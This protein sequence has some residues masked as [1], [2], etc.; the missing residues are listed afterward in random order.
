[1]LWID[2][3]G[4]SATAS[5]AMAAAL[6]A[7]AARNPLVAVMGSVAGSG[8]YY[9]ATPAARIFAQPSTLTGSIGV[10][11]GKLAVGGL[12][13]RLLLNLETVT[14]RE[15][16]SMFGPARAFRGEDEVRLRE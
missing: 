11:S 8:G 15:H 3:G 4:G 16:A 12:L 9:V 7:L 6:R 10:L 5:E 13:Q 14:R 1:V 2:S